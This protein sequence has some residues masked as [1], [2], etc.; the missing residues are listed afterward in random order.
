MENTVIFFSITI[1]FPIIVDWLTFCC[2][3]RLSMSREWWKSHVGVRPS[4][5][6]N[7][8]YDSFDSKWRQDRNTVASVHDL[9]WLIR[10]TTESHQE[11]RNRISKISHVSSSRCRL[12]SYLSVKQRLSGQR[13]NIQLYS[14]VRQEQDWIL[15]SKLN[16]KNVRTTDEKVENRTS[17]QEA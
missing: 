1:V 14:I 15:R 10:K 2:L 16:Y 8:I 6:Q 7:H 17:S 11:S 9:N 12:Q 4:S 13:S 3:I 5:V